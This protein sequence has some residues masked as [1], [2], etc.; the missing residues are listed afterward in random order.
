DNF[1]ELGGDSILAMQ[2]V[3][4]AA[5]AGIQFDSAELFANQTIA[6]LAQVAKLDSAATPAHFSTPTPHRFAPTPIQQWFLNQSLANANHFNQSVCLRLA[7]QVDKQALQAAIDAVFKHHDSLRLRLFDGELEYTLDNPPNVEWFDGND[8]DD[9]AHRLA[10][11]L[12]LVEGPLFRIAAS[13]PTDHDSAT[14]LIL[15][16]H[17]FVVDAVS[18]RVLLDDLYDCYRQALTDK[19]PLLAAKTAT[20][21]A[22]SQVLHDSIGNAVVDKAFW[23]EMV[24]NAH[25]ANSPL[26]V[27]NPTIANSEKLVKTLPRELTRRLLQGARPEQRASIESKLLTALVEVIAARFAINSVTID[28]EHHGREDSQLG[29]EFDVSRTVGWFTTIFPLTLPRPASAS[30]EQQLR[31]VSDQLA[32]VSER[33]ISYGVLRYLAGFTELECSPEI[34]FNFLGNIDAIDS[35][36]RFQRIDLDVPPSAPEN[37]RAHSVDLNCWI[38]DGRLHAEWTFD[39]RVSEDVVAVAR[40]FMLML[41]QI[42]VVFEPESKAEED[43]FDLVDLRPDQLSDILSKVSFGGTDRQ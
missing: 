6:E 8:F 22:W 18:W 9:V 19:T 1:F 34:S 25:G 27:A 14:V 26:A 41:E 10:G 32:A 4:R 17:H 28:L 2:V 30:I 39:H 24:Q 20:Y 7:N 13:T 35:L 43:A 3:S 11:D 38:Q 23:A 12:N 15:V 40:D 21:Q 31:T 29:C 16:A 36:E 42:A 33:G 37:Q 5:R